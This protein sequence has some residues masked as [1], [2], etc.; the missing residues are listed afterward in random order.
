MSAV[1]SN[2]KETCIC[3]VMFS[4]GTRSVNDVVLVSFQVLLS[5]IQIFL[6]TSPVLLHRLGPRTPSLRMRRNQR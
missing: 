2:D 5:R 4:C 1:K 3:V 6:L